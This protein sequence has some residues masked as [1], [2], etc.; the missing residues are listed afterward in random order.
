MV[1]TVT[2]ACVM[3]MATGALTATG[4]I[5]IVI[6]R[7]SV[8]FVAAGAIVHFW[9]VKPRGVVFDQNV[10]PRGS[11]VEKLI[12]VIIVRLKSVIAVDYK[13]GF[14]CVGHPYLISSPTQ[15]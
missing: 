2:D 1:T 13:F 5:T 11:R 4:A 7:G 3:L 12:V 15:N 14:A 10:L 6:R 8:F 9:V